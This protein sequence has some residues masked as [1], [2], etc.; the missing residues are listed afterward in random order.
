MVL[1][2]IKELVLYKNKGMWSRQSSDVEPLFGSRNSIG[3]FSLFITVNNKQFI[4]FTIRSGPFSA[5]R[6]SYCAVA[7][8]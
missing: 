3:T 5:F 4:E 2:V 6:M 8:A 1:E 7:N